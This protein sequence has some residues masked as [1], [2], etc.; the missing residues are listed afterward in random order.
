MER[1][2]PRKDAHPVSLSPAE[3]GRLEAMTSK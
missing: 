3:R 2:K 1:R